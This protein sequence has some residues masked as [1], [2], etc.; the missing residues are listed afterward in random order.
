MANLKSGTPLYF[1]GD[2]LYPYW[3][4]VPNAYKMDR[5]FEN[6][7]KGKVHS[8]GYGIPE[9]NKW[10]WKRK[11]A[12]DADE[13]E[14]KPS[15]KGGSAGAYANLTET[16]SEGTLWIKV[17]FPFTFFNRDGVPNH[18]TDTTIW[19]WVKSDEVA[20][21]K[22]SAQ[23][24]KELSDSLNLNPDKGL[25]GSGGTT[26]TSKSPTTLIV[27]AAVLVFVGIIIFAFRK[28]KSQATNGQMSI[29]NPNAGINVIR[30]PK[31]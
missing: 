25:T 23:T 13:A 21:K 4:P 2:N 31:N 24:L 7:L 12:D 20:T 18:D 14:I 22:D 26:T 8:W 28:P 17:D 16:D 6:V 1:V 19:A 9:Q 29:N 27:V 11:F 10:R 30:I 15:K 5:V 3:E